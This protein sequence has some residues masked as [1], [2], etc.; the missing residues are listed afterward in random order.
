MARLYA[1]HISYAHLCMNPICA[2]LR[3]LLIKDKSEFLVKF[4]NFLP[5]FT[6]GKSTT[7]SRLHTACFVYTFSS[8]ARIEF[9]E[10]FSW[11]LFNTDEPNKKASTHRRAQLWPAVK[12]LRESEDCRPVR[13]KIDEKCL[14]WELCA[15]ELRIPLILIWIWLKYFR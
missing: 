1:L 5:S 4:I 6:G 9:S 2:V 3:F 13:W 11:N 8:E 12:T 14:R 10:K 15:N 7:F